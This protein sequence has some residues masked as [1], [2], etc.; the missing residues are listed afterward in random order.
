MAMKGNKRTAIA[1]SID[2]FATEAAPNP[3]SEIQALS[4]DPDF[5][6]SLARG[7]CVLQAFA[8]HMRGVTVSQLAAATGLSRAAVRRCLHTLTRLGYAA[9]DDTAHCVLLPK[10][11]ALGYAYFSSK[12]FVQVA[13]S[14][15]DRLGSIIGESCSLSV[16]DGDEIVYVVRTSV[17]RI[18][19]LDLHVGSR[20]PAFCTSMGRVLLASLPEDQLDSYLAR[21]TLRHHTDRTV[22]S[23][24]KLRRLITIVRRTGF[25]ITDQELEIGLRSIAVPVRASSGKVIG[26]LNAATHVARV[27]TAELHSKILPCLLE[28]AAELTMLT[29]TNGDLPHSLL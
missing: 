23:V 11:M 1:K 8:R 9:Y 15:L 3:A 22:N 5:M 12:P 14:V 6:T 20:L 10:V 25:S 19:A 24:A 18:M 29:Q 13:Q 26:A 7:L 16:L 4:G 27:S 21:V 28:S 17:T 2:R